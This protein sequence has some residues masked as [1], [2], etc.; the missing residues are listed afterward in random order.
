MSLH[1]NL[2]NT[3]KK[4]NW[5]KLVSPESELHLTLYD[6]D[7]NKTVDMNLV[8]EYFFSPLNQKR[9]S[10]FQIFAGDEDFVEQQLE[11][12]R[13]QLPDSYRLFQNYP[14]PFNS[15]TIINF[16]L[17]KEKYVKLIL[18]NM[19][20]EEQKILVQ[21]N[22]GVGF[23]KV[24]LDAKELSSGLYIYKL[25]TGGFVDVKKLVVLK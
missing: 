20:G 6:K 22:Y 23:H 7:K 2:S 24:L 12:I 14:N 3:D 5:E 9:V 15:T 21:D 8:S 16:E 18:Y 1:S 11:E 17:P 19:I 10:N 13:S 25:E 4:L